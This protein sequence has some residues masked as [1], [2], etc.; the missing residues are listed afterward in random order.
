MR[1]AFLAL[2]FEWKIQQI[3]G[4]AGGIRQPENGISPQR[5]RR[6]PDS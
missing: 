2:L 3:C 5:A 6:N 4:K 1:Y